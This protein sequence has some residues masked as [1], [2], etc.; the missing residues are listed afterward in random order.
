MRIAY[1]E[2]KQAFQGRK[3]D[4]NIWTK[5]V[6]KAICYADYRYLKGCKMITYDEA[7]KLSKEWQ[8][9]DSDSL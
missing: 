8:N 6:K 9:G 1:S 7:E 5:D 2:K 4:Y 3:G